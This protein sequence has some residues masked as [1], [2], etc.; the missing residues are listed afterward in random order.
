[1]VPPAID[2]LPMTRTFS[3]TIEARDG[4]SLARAG[5]IKTAHGLIP[6]PIFM[7]VGTR[8]TVKAV[9][10]D[11]LERLGARIILGN[12]YHLML[13]PGEELVAEMGGLHK[14][15]GWSGP[16]LTDSGGFQ[17]FSLSKLRK[18]TEEG[19]TFQSPYDGSRAFLSP[20]RSI[21][22]QSRLGVDIM[23]CLDECTGYPASREEAQK[24]MD[25]THRWARRCKAAWEKNPGDRVLFGI[26]QGS[27]YPDLRRRS[28]EEI[29]QLDLPGQAVGGLALGEPMPDRL[30]AL[31]AA[32]EALDEA[33]P[34]YL[35]GLGL[36]EDIIEGILRGADMF[37][38]VIPTRNGRNGQLFTRL[39]KLGIKNAR[40]RNDPRPLDEKC[41]CYT[42]RTFSRAYLRH[43]FQNSEPLAMR[44]S[45]VH[46]LQYYLD[47]VRGAREALLN[48]S[49]SGYY[50]EFY[51]NLR[52]GREEG[53]SA[54]FPAAG[55]M[56]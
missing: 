8:G 19:V 32:R 28:A 52:Q 44:L 26:S 7:P 4:Q 27:F 50:A 15:M 24:S 43:L 49:F 42:C 54:S 2:A 31:E 51:E 35:M 37:D 47:L 38:C 23:M 11:D 40:F 10:P 18:M 22:V 16:I 20:E 13:R 53:L 1:M 3:F 34:M 36:P 30:T 9:A 45:A 5:T 12:T 41:S 33:K 56:I 39:G 25:L 14:F 6:T 48:G 21:E 46:N 17:V 55:K 29:A